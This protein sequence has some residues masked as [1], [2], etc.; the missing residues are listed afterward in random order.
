MLIIWHFLFH[1]KLHHYNPNGEDD[2]RRTDKSIIEPL[3]HVTHELVLYYFESSSLLCCP[4]SGTL[5]S[6]YGCFYC[7]RQYYPC[8]LFRCV[9]DVQCCL[10]SSVIGFCM[11][12]FHSAH[13][14]TEYITQCTNQKSA[15][16]VELNQ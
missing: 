9:T 10:Y 6:I 1:Q 4:T 15:L 11:H 5:Q 13:I 7:C 12:N 8:E 2:E 16:T 14:F 3:T